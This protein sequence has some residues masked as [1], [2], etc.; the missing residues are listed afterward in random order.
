MD[1]ARVE[2]LRRQIELYRQCLRR[3]S[4]AEVAAIYVRELATAE[5]ELAELEK[6][7]G[8]ATASPL[9]HP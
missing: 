5:L 8:D 7:A 1:K 4:G 9:L 6:V 2:T 3:T